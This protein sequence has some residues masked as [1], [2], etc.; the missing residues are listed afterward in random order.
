ML[1]RLPSLMSSK[2]VNPEQTVLAVVRVRQMEVSITFFRDTK[3]CAWMSDYDTRLPLKMNRI[4]LLE[5]SK[6]IDT[7]TWSHI[8]EDLNL[9][10]KCCEDIMYHIKGGSNMT[11]TN[12]DL[13]TQKSS[14]SYLN[15]LVCR[16]GNL[17]VFFPLRGVKTWSQLS[18]DQIQLRCVT[19][20]SESGSTTHRCECIAHVKS[21]YK[22]DMS[23]STK[24]N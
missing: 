5:S 19:L 20:S 24:C 9:Q 8:P 22:Y 1:Y 21:R 12:C 4:S 10:Q 6:T 11:G 7:V 15:H 23:K 17:L 3:V 2:A 14:R 18:L 13:F 16:N